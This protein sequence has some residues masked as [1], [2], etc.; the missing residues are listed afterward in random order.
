MRE[1]FRDIA[2]RGKKMIQDEMVEKGA[3]SLKKGIY[4][5]VDDN[6]F[7]IS[8]SEAAYW[9]DGGRPSEAEL[10]RRTKFP[11]FKSISA[12]MDKHGIEKKALYPIC[13]K[14]RIHGTKG[15]YYFNEPLAKITDMAADEI[16]EEIVTR[17]YDND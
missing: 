17:Y 3:S 5:N 11:P 13:R 8:A 16:Q 7:T 15:K 4:T 10:G 1:L 12:W 9:A 14:I 2:K 6:G